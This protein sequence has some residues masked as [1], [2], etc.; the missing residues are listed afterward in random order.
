MFDFFKKAPA[1]DE[2]TAVLEEEIA[3]LE[4]LAS[5]LEAQVAALEEITRTLTPSNDGK[6]NKAKEKSGSADKGKKKE[7]AAPSK[8]EVAIAEVMEKTGWSREETV[9]KIEDAKSRLGVSYTEYAR[10]ELYDVPEQKQQKEYQKIL[11]KR[12]REKKNARKDRAAR[13]K[14]KYLSQL[15]EITG[16][17]RAYAEEKMERAKEVAGSSYE[18]YVIYRF[19]E[20]TEEEQKTYFTKRD[21]VQLRKKYNT[22]PKVLK[23]LMNKDLC[24]KKLEKFLGRPWM[25]TQDMTY[26]SF[27]SKFAGEKKI[28]Y[29]PRS[30]S[31]GHGI[32]IFEIAPGSIKEVYDAIKALPVGIVEGY[33]V[34]HPKMM[35][36]SV[37]SVNTIRIVTI[38]T[39]SVVP[40]LEKD[41]VNF[42]YAGIRM[43]Q[44]GNFVDNLHS[45]GLIA[46]VDV[47][48]GVV[49]TG[50]VDHTNVIHYQ[51]PDTKTDLIGFQIPFFNEA[52]QMIEA[53][54]VDLPGY[55]G[56][57]VAI[58]EKGPVIIEVNTSPGADGLQT[59]FVPE[60]R[61]MRHVIEK[62]L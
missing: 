2:K 1:K 58:T 40:G 8:R 61:G 51:H 36:L 12:E 33:L 23:T 43:G 22:D 35:Q 55:F 9:S 31:G 54:S 42:L 59:P 41:K 20:L 47:G 44:G 56:W 10:C 28:I 60:K 45:G 30:S 37:N 24:C 34:Q 32:Q 7:A 57:D 25:S 15:V 13:K 19:W 46:A 27:S 29:K 49:Q 6:K 62:Y 16:W 18:H 53:A 21:A 48:T 26:E 38:K 11:E 5:K 39:D 4:A 17:D 52:K 14:E 3:A 50:A